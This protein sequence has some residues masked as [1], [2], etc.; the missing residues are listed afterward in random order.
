QAS[1]PVQPDQWQGPRHAS[2]IRCVRTTAQHRELGGSPDERGRINCP[3]VFAMEQWDAFWKVLWSRTKPPPRAPPSPGLLR[4]HRLTP[5]GTRST[6]TGPNPL[7]SPGSHSSCT[8]AA[9]PKFPK[10]G[11]RTRNASPGAAWALRPPG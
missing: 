10:P 4:S 7:I 11:L 6:E 9:S 5:E 8:Q 1:T 2:G 3:P